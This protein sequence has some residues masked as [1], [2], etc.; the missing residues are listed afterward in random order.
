MAQLFLILA[1]GCAVWCALS[2]GF[3]SDTTYRPGDGSGA[4]LSIIISGLA[5][6]CFF[7]AAA[8]TALVN[9]IGG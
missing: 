2:F 1:I 9:V 5:S 4:V 6:I 7:M 3:V 8:L